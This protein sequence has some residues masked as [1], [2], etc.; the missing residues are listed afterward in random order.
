M[1]HLAATLKKG[2]IKDLLT[3][4]PPNKRTGKYLEDHFKA[5]GLTQVADWWTKKQFSVI[6]DEFVKSITDLA[7]K[8]EP[9]DVVRMLL[10][11]HDRRAHNKLL[12]II[13][14][15]KGHQRDSPI[16][17]TDLIQCIWQGLMASVDW[18]ARPD[19]I[20]GLALRETGVS[21]DHYLI[22][23]TEGPA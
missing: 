18:S 13:E 23:V 15:I 1:D 22:P 17:E 3:F 21:F 8:D 2:G 16:P 6:K 10:E 4:F 20:E 9:V 7:E 19:Q 11:H 12:Q 5:E 14:V